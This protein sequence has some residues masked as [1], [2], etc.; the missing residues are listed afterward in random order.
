MRARAGDFLVLLAPTL[1]VGVLV[2]VVTRDDP[3][4][5]VPVLLVLLIVATIGI[6]FGLILL[7]HTTR[8]PSTFAIVVWQEQA[9]FRVQPNFRRQCV[10]Y[11]VLGAALVL[12]AFNGFRV[13]HL[14]VLRAMSYGIIVLTTLFLLVLSVRMLRS[15]PLVL[16]SEGLAIDGGR[17][18]V[19]WD[20]LGARAESG[21]WAVGSPELVRGRRV[22]EFRPGEDVPLEVSLYFLTRVIDLYARQPE[23]RAAIGTAEELERLRG[24]LTRQVT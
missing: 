16:T 6:A 13:G 5:Y 22:R 7:A 12:M 9:A 8:G 4:A 17:S 1:V 21:A 11:G 23:R 15:G 19:P 14:S 24:A 3:A 20:A 2:P 10:F 18:F